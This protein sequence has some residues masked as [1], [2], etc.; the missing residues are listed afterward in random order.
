[1]LF[2]SA[3]GR[4][5]ATDAVSSRLKEAEDDLDHGKNLSFEGAGH[6]IVPATVSSIA[7]AP[8]IAKVG[9]PEKTLA[10]YP[11]EVSRVG[12]QNVPTTPFPVLRRHLQR[13]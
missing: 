10:A 7:D 6:G 5:S 1:M 12:G 8:L 2:R 3:E 4:E 13:S 9:E 11:E